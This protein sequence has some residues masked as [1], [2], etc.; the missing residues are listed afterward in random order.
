M[1]AVLGDDDDQLRQSAGLEPVLEMDTGDAVGS[2]DLAYHGR[3]DQPG[4]ASAMDDFGVQRPVMPDVALS[5]EDD[6]RSVCP[7]SRLAS[8]SR[9]TSHSVSVMFRPG[10]MRPP[11]RGRDQ[12]MPTGLAVSIA[13]IE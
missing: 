2:V 6:N 10:T 3:L 12:A 11:R 13:T 4:R 1:D 7:E 9:M 8:R 5:G